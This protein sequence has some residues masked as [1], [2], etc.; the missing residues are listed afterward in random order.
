LTAFDALSD[1]RYERFEDSTFGKLLLDRLN[2]Q[3]SIIYKVHYLKQ[4]VAE[5]N[6]LLKGNE[7]IF[8][9]SSKIY[10]CLVLFQFNVYLQNSMM[11][12]RYASVILHSVYPAAIMKLGFALI[13]RSSKSPAYRQD[14]GLGTTHSCTCNGKNLK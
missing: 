7:K 2:E 12:A 9:I 4:I 6:I 5:A 1:P 3:P 14:A 13:V 10:F 11:F 8:I